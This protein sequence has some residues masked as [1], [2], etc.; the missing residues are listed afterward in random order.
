MPFSEITPL[1][2]NVT[3]SD[4]A[5]ATT[6]ETSLVVAMKRLNQAR[7]LPGQEPG[8]PV[9][10]NAFDAFISPRLMNGQLINAI[11]V[12]CATRV[13]SLDANSTVIIL[14]E[15]LGAK[16]SVAYTATLLHS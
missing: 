8:E 15:M 4:I 2:I 16:P 11:D 6:T 10:G 14:F 12:L 9:D 13:Y 1:T 3:T 7:Q 5:V